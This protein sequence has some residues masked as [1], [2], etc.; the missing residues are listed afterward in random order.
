[1]IIKLI[2]LLYKDSSDWICQLI[3]QW[4]IIWREMWTTLCLHSWTNG[5]W[6]EN[7]LEII[8]IPQLLWQHIDKNIPPL[9]WHRKVSEVLLTISQNE[10]SIHIL[11]VFGNVRCSYF[12]TIFRICQCEERNLFTLISFCSLS[13]NQRSQRM[14]QDVD[15]VVIY[16]IFFPWA[17]QD[18]HRCSSCSINS[19][20]HFN[21]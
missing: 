6:R 21:G 19:S 1:M 10:W 8:Q 4:T 11:K 17:K 12:K 2:Q 5:K 3:W 16:Y 13:L 15:I 20:V 18:L 9:T 14:S 7:K